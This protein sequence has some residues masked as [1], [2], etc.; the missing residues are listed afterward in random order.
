MNQWL[1]I[2][3]RE[4]W[5]VPRIFLVSFDGRTVLFDCPFD[6]ASEDYPDSYKVYVLPDATEEELAGSWEKLYKRAVSFLGKVPIER[7]LFDPTHRQAIDSKVLEE[8][9]AEV[10]T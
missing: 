5:D 9:I 1:P 8:L 3:Y 10:R 6:E 4:I 2:Q 7:V